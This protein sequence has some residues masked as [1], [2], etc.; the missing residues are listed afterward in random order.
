MLAQEARLTALDTQVV[1]LYT[2]IADK[3]EDI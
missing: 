2:L 3:W 1:C